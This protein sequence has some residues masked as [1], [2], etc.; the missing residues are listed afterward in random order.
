MLGVL[1]VDFRFFPYLLYIFNSHIY[2][3]FNTIEFSTH[4]FFRHVLT[5]ASVKLKYVPQN[6]VNFK[7]RSL[8]WGRAASVVAEPQ[9]FGF[10]CKRPSIEFCLKE[11]CRKICI[12][13]GLVLTEFISLG[14]MVEEPLTEVV[15]ACFFVQE[16]IL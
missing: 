15:R 12:A 11:V 4:Y 9:N 1:H 13:G 10:H 6:L 8:I 16:I 7:L 2:L 3:F 14:Y 5:I